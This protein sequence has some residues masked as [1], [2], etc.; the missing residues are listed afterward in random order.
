MT[1]SRS[2]RGR[3]SANESGDPEPPKRANRSTARRS[4]ASSTATS[5]SAQLASELA[6]ASSS[7]RSSRRTTTRQT[8]PS[9][10]SPTSRSTSTDASATQSA[11]PTAAAAARK[12]RRKKQTDVPDN[13]G[14]RQ[15][16]AAKPEMKSK[17]S[18]AQRTEARRRSRS[19][20][21][22]ADVAPSDSHNDHSES[23]KDFANG[24]A[25]RHGSDIIQ[26]HM[27]ASGVG[28]EPVGGRVSPIYSW[29]SWY[30]GCT[31]SEDE[32][33]DEGGTSRSLVGAHM[34]NQGYNE[35]LTMQHCWTD[36]SP[37]SF[38]PSA[39]VFPSSGS[40]LSSNCITPAK[41]DSGLWLPELLLQLRNDS[42]SANTPR[43][44][45]ASESYIND[46]QAE[47]D[48]QVDSTIEFPSPPSHSRDVPSYADRAVFSHLSTTAQW[49]LDAVN[50]SATASAEAAKLLDPAQPPATNMGHAEFMRPWLP[51]SHH[52]V[53]MPFSNG[54]GQAGYPSTSA[55]PEQHLDSSHATPMTY[56]QVPPFA[57]SCHHSHNSQFPP[58]APATTS[59]G[60][61]VSSYAY[62][63][64][65][66][67][68]PPCPNHSQYPA[69][70]RSAY[71]PSGPFNHSISPPP[72]PP[73][74]PATIQ[75]QSNMNDPNRMVI[76]MDHPTKDKLEAL[77]AALNLA[78]IKLV[79][80]DTASTSR[81]HSPFHSSS[82]TV[83]TRD[84]GFGQDKTAATT[85]IP[86][87]YAV[88]CQYPP[89]PNGYCYASNNQM[90]PQHYAPVPPPP[91]PM[92][93][94]LSASGVSDI[95]PLGPLPP[96]HSSVF[97]A[98]SS[99]MS[100]MLALRPESH[101][102]THNC[103]SEDDNNDNG[104]DADLADAPPRHVP[105][106][107]KPPKGIR[108]APRHS[109]APPSQPQQEDP[110]L[111]AQREKYRQRAL[112]AAATRKQ[113]REAAQVTRDTRAERAEK[114]RLLRLNASQ[115]QA[116]VV[117][118]QRASGMDELVL[119]EGAAGGIAEQHDDAMEGIEAGEQGTA[120]CSGN[121]EGKE[122]EVADESVDQTMEPA[123]ADAP[124]KESNVSGRRRGPKLTA[125]DL[126][127]D[128]TGMNNEQIARA[129]RCANARRAAAAS[130]ASRKRKR[131]LDSAKGKG[132]DK[133]KQCIVSEGP[134]PPGSTRHELREDFEEEMQLANTASVHQE[135][136]VLADPSEVAPITGQ[137]SEPN[138]EQ[139]EPEHPEPF[140]EPE[141]SAQ[142]EDSEMEG[143]QGDLDGTG[144]ELFGLRLESKEPDLP[145]P[146]GGCNTYH[147][148]QV[149][150]EDGHKEGCADE[151]DEQQG[152]V[153]SG[154][155]EETK[156][157][158]QLESTHRIVT[159][160]DNDPIE[161][162]EDDRGHIHEQRM[163]SA[164]TD[165]GSESENPTIADPPS[166]PPKRVRRS[167]RIARS[168][169]SLPIE[170]EPIIDSTLNAA[171]PSVDSENASSRLRTR[172]QA[173]QDA[174][175]S[176]PIRQ[177]Y[178]KS[179]DVQGAGDSGDRSHLASR[180]RFNRKRQRQPSASSD[181]ETTSE[182][183]AGV[184]DLHIEKA[185]GV[186]K[187]SGLDQPKARR[188][189]SRKSR[190]RAKAVVEGSEAVASPD[191]MSADESQTQAPTVETRPP[192]RVPSNDQGTMEPQLDS[193]D[194]D[195]DS[196]TEFAQQQ[197]LQ[198]EP[199]AP[200]KQSNISSDPSLVLS[201]RQSPPGSPTP[202]QSFSVADT[203][204][205]SQRSSPALA[206][207]ATQPRHI[208]D[209]PDDP[210]VSDLNQS[211]PIPRVDSA[212]MGGET[213]NDFMTVDSQDRNSHVQPQNDELVMQRQQLF[214]PSDPRLSPA[215]APL[216]HSSPSTAWLKTQPTPMSQ[217]ST[218][219]APPA[220]MQPIILVDEERDPN[221]PVRRGR[222]PGNTYLRIKASEA[223]QSGLL[224]G[225]PKLPSRRG[226][227]PKHKSASTDSASGAA[228][229]EQK[230][231]ARTPER[232]ESTRESLLSNSASANQTNHS[233]DSDSGHPEPDP[234]SASPSTSS[235]DDSALLSLPINLGSL[236]PTH[237][238]RT[239]P[240]QSTS[241]ASTSR[242]TARQF[243]SAFRGVSSSTSL[244]PPQPSV[245]PAGHSQVSDWNKPSISSPGPQSPSFT[246]F[247]PGSA[248]RHNA[249]HFSG[250]IRQVSAVTAI[251]QKQGMQ[252]QPVPTRYVAAFTSPSFT[253]QWAA[254]NP[255]S[256][257]RQHPP[258]PTPIEDNS[259][260]AL[261]SNHT[262]QLHHPRA[263][264][265]APPQELYPI[266]PHILNAIHDRCNS[267][268]GPKRWQPVIIEDSDEEDLYDSDQ[269][270]TW[271]GRPRMTDKR[272][273]KM[274][275]RAK[276]AE[277]A[278]KGP[279]FCRNC[280][281]DES[282]GWRWSKLERKTLLCNAC[283]MWERR[284]KTPKKVDAN[285]PCL[286][287]G[288]NV[289]LPKE[290]IRPMCLVR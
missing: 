3:S 83:H 123:A 258:P 216:A 11:A 281:T 97:S 89:P 88:Q 117:A 233:R 35:C 139:L 125:A 238:S 77:A 107:Q 243:T 51:S 137:G 248:A 5:E 217:P 40:N 111:D 87:P 1:A 206:A 288:A 84:A 264:P 94:S 18:S 15:S 135:R 284:H 31:G 131:M 270:W 65:Q 130:V 279:P 143:E 70:H 161:Q 142:H 150:E 200:L 90:Y 285:M 43:H 112:L 256:S 39:D 13:S 223:V 207:V 246:S 126:G 27:T 122:R 251:Q 242:S 257:T 194:V 244:F 230:D 71:P 287:C 128:T 201:L 259:I 185:S 95:G 114:R 33:D 188:R 120:A 54:L 141:A 263:E 235:H 265:P 138:K 166:P 72:P 26:Q 255:S 148:M 175:R 278:L 280:Y 106:K 9:S 57:Q 7:T 267:K 14:S 42:S 101:L 52:G 50:S 63:H 187:D 48:M 225:Q 44:R 8:G 82:H 4:A 229:N 100:P 132:K 249:Q 30:H 228:A 108:R 273:K 32:D 20:R 178:K 113:K 74:P 86:D 116:P 170:P 147:E 23:Q 91:P 69:H 153:E 266:P 231:S 118:E 12:P 154:D 158:T 103:D 193:M 98:F 196:S 182:S 80:S 220:P 240:A 214:E 93:A 190:R 159:D 215:S 124:L 290:E 167:T 269:E 58:S 162:L 181:Q 237:P 110:A 289:I 202:E 34:H 209:D 205:T 213:D 276:Q 261:T 21:K 186:Q 247:P 79:A 149:E 55:W 173:E 75:I 283:A 73:P 212:A 136:I 144:A 180:T 179:D 25:A 245:T 109:T 81:P 119:D 282:C 129:I 59:T 151:A 174:I 2:R 169:G 146:L 16:A 99:P 134:P 239:S 226:R 232:R 29:D 49:T 211:P 164:G 192:W 236:S 286:R 62:S 219:G 56:V 102:R 66:A 254:R 252:S 53:S 189:S 121:E 19:K 218:P 104:S 210:M 250:V 168:T 60:N 115:V 172:R 157:D 165:S 17:V 28:Y 234:P 10:S 145:E 262:A 203:S 41:A 183:M 275:K 191:A 163:P 227:P 68:N 24:G 37:A 78:S 22:V 160:H 127:V 76:I 204:P 105:A 36:T 208:M 46:T 195:N 272:R 156:S 38:C 47:D 198:K 277:R 45:L 92:M 274:Q 221:V 64:P 6:P 241:S 197:Q 140:E 176:S 85:H 222:P 268:P 171:G 199:A 96:M 177:R 61:Q 271:T 224:T 253:G 184:S 133:D 67:S 155:A 152:L 260:P